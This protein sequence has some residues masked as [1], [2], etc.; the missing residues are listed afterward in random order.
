MS[1]VPDWVTLTQGEEVVWDAQ[2]SLVPYLATLT[3]EL[4]VVVIGV[5]IW[6]A[7]GLAPLLGTSFNP[8]VPVLSMSLWSVVAILLIGWGVLGIASTVLRWWSI[9]YLVTTEEIYKKTGLLSRTVANTRLEQV[10]N[11]AFTQSWL[12]RL[13]S[14]GDVQ[15]DTAGTAGREI[16]FENV[17]DPDEIIETITRQLDRV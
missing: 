9:R 13:T 1:D 6:L 4:V 12:G 15:I 17:G 8:A 16:V 11:T 3:G 2:P 14:Y 10:Q 7:G 5:V